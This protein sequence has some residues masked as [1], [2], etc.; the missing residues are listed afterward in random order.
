MAGNVW[1][2]VEDTY[3]GDYAGAPSDGSAWTRESN[4]RLA[5]GGSW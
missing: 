3:Q 5:R 4:L 1:Q 2:W